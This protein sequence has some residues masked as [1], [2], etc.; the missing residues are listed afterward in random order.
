MNNFLI[1]SERSVGHTVAIA[2]KRGRKRIETHEQPAEIH[3]T[4]IIF[5]SHY[6]WSLYE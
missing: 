1:D 3:P 6:L 5:I 2:D 4:R